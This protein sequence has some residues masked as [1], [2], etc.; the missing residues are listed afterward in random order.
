[1]KTKELIDGAIIYSIAIILSPLILTIFLIVYCNIVCS[2]Y[3]LKK[4]LGGKLVIETN[5]KDELLSWESINECLSNKHH[6]M[7]WG[8]RCPRCKGRVYQI[9]SATLYDKENWIETGL[10]GYLELC[11]KCKKQIGV[12]CIGKGL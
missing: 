7:F 2:R 4:D 12:S 10:D 11:S 9:W 8:K 3:L 6:I 1:M 5:E